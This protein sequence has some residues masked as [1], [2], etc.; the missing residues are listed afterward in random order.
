MTGARG[1]F[2]P[3]DGLET[4]RFRRPRELWRTINRIVIGQ[5]EGRHPERRCPIH[6][7]LD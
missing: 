5:G 2:R 7:R 4:R 6:D 1:Q 3:E